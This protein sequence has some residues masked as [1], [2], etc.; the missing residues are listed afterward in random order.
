MVRTADR[1]QPVFV[2]MTQVAWHEFAHAVKEQLAQRWHAE[3]GRWSPTR[4]RLVVSLRLLHPTEAATTRYLAPLVTWLAAQC[5]EVQ[6]TTSY[7]PEHRLYL[8]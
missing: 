7:K 4:V 1:R 6:V 8:D 3:A 2:A 5:G